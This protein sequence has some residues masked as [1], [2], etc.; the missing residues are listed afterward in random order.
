MSKLPRD[1]IYHYEYDGKWNINI[2]ITDL[3]RCKDCKWWEQRGYDGNCHN[4]IWGDGW[5]NY[6][7]PSTLEEGFCYRAERRGEEE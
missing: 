7:S 6:P 3:I 4:P 2:T 5:A 1:T